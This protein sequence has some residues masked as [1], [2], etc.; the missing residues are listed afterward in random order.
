[1]DIDQVSRVE[2]RANFLSVFLMRIE[3]PNVK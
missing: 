1:M 2:K 3:D